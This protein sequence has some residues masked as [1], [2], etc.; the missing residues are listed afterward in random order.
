[1]DWAVEQTPMFEIAQLANG[2]SFLMGKP[3]T[4]NQ[5][6]LFWNICCFIKLN[7]KQL[8]FHQHVKELFQQILKYEDIYV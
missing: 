3:T 2:F 5:V 7:T 6:K 4:Q 8:S 1:M